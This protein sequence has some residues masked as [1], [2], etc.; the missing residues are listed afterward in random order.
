M[1]CLL[2]RRRFRAAHHRSRCH[3]RIAG[4]D[5]HVDHGDFAGLDRRDRLLEGVDQLV[6]LVHG[7]KTLRA[8][9]A[10]ER[11]DVDV[12]CRPCAWRSLVGFLREHDLVSAQTGTIDGSLHETRGLG[13]LNKLADIGQPSNPVLRDG[14][15]NEI[16]SIAVLEHPGSR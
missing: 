6:L 4:L 8:L 5:P 15:S 7:P 3:R 10:R 1:W 12:S 16:R 13:L 14:Q 11:G 9:R 2:L